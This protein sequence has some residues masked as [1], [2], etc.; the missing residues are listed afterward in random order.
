MARKIF[1]NLAVEDLA[2]TKAFWEHCGFGFDERFSGEHS[3]CLVIS[4]EIH[5]MLLTPERFWD[6]ALKPLVDTAQATEVM[7]CITLDSREEVDAVMEKAKEQGATEWRLPT[8]YG[9]MY[10]RSFE[11]L[12]G[13]I[14]EWMW[15]QV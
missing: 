15:I 4:S 9:M 7:T 13:H 12:D 5:A 10:S 6:F 11:D 1:V 8:D 3:L 14:W 2:Q